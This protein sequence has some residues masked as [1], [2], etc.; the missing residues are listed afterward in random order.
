MR[1]LILTSLMFSPIFILAACD[2]LSPPSRA[3]EICH[4][5]A[6]GRVKHPGS[7]VAISQMEDN[8]PNGQVTVT[9]N[10]TSWNGFKVPIPYSI[11]CEFQVQGEKAS[12]TLLSITWNKRPIRHHELDEIKERFEV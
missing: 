2:I 8:K 6:L 3:Q 10:F 4:D 11:S 9:L 5:V 7:Y 1:H 12:L